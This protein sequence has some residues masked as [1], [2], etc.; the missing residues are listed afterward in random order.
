MKSHGKI[1][2]YL[3]YSD[4]CRA[5]KCR[6]DRYCFVIDTYD[7]WTS[8]YIGSWFIHVQDM[9]EAKK[10]LRKERTRWRKSGFTVLTR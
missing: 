6:K 1:R 8:K 2:L 10:I 9:A 4:Y 7:G 3:R 5:K